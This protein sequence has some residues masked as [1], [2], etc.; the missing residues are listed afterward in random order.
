MTT[1]REGVNLVACMPSTQTR[2]PKWESRGARERKMSQEA[3]RPTGALIYWQQAQRK[4]ATQGSLIQGLSGI[5]AQTRMVYALTPNPSPKMG[6]GLRRL[7][8]NGDFSVESC[9][10][11]QVSKASK[12]QTD[13]N[14]QLPDKPYGF[15]NSRRWQDVWT[16]SRQRHRESC[17]Q[18]D[19]GALTVAAVRQILDVG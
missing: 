12:P 14:P 13:V 3:G 17:E 19:A 8:R 2:L 16:T 4:R 5:L 7:V 18:A 11:C 15:R 6:E 1:R 10:F 9:A